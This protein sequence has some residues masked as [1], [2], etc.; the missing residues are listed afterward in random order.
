MSSKKQDDKT[1]QDDSRR[2]V[3]WEIALAMF[4]LFFILLTFVNSG[5]SGVKH[6]KEPVSLSSP[7]ILPKLPPSHLILEEAFQ[8][9]RYELFNELLEQCQQAR[10]S[11]HII[12]TIKDCDMNNNIAFQSF[13]HV[14]QHLYGHSIETL[15]S[16][17]WKSHCEE[18]FLTL[19]DIRTPLV[20]QA[21][22]F[23]AIPFHLKPEERIN[24]KIT[25]L[26]KLV[27][28][29]P[30]KIDSELKLVVVTVL[31]NYHPTKLR[32]KIT[33]LTLKSACIHNIPIHVLGTH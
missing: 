33:S 21:A 27:W 1:L 22:S 8:G 10:N 14:L 32:S 17:S 25:E 13:L 29:K 15:T 6:R 12:P 19:K 4:V 30:T 7:S 18:Q 31:T 2:R 26:N 20:C 11:S 23:V 3:E 9:K 16:N 28:Q 5:I 24:S